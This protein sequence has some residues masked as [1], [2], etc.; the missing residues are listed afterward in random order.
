MKQDFSFTRNPA[1]KMAGFRV[2]PFR[3]TWKPCFKRGGFLQVRNKQSHCCAVRRTRI[4]ASLAHPVTHSGASWGALWRK[5]PPHVQKPNLHLSH[6][7]FQK[8]CRLWVQGQ[9]VAERKP[10]T[11]IYFCRDRLNLAP[12]QRR[13]AKISLSVRQMQVRF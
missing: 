1:K 4:G 7:E 11:D 12:V 5:P 2:S 6:A 10:R 8:T 13:I 9:M 3:R